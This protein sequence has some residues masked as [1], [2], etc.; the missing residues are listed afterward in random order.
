M[1]P[2][3]SLNVY[4]STVSRSEFVWG[5]HDCLTFTNDAFHAMYGVGWADDWLGRYMDGNRVLGRGELKREFKCGDFNM[6]VDKKLKRVE[7]VPPLGALVTTKRARKWVTGVAMGICTGTK[8]AFLDKVGVIYLP[9]DQI[10][11][12]W[13]SK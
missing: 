5:K 6:A 13:V 8:A 4:I 12:A 11:A 7:H 9:L 1:G 10:D 3:D 2:R